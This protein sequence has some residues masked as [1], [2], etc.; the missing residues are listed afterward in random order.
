LVD[1]YGEAK[2][3]RRGIVILAA[4]L[5]ISASAH[6]WPVLFVGLTLMP[7]GTACLFP[8]VT[9][10]LSRVVPSG[11][12][13]MYMGVQQTFG[14]VSRVAFPVAAGLM[15]DHLGRSTPFLVAA[16]MVLA[17]LPLAAGLDAILA[18]KRGAR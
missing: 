7:L 5:A 13:G 9:G 2:L 3:A 4:G 12:R 16:V 18:E 8:S 1:H 14:G 17:T 6:T 15:M 11:Q 10:M